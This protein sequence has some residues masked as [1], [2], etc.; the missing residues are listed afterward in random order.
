[1]VDAC[2]PKRGGN[3]RGESDWRMNWTTGIRKQEGLEKT[4]TFRSALAEITRRG[5]Q[6]DRDLPDH[7]AG[8]H[9][10][11]NSFQTIHPVLFDPVKEIRLTDQNIGDLFT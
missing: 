7:D 11:T 1:M 10:I 2:C 8:F 3:P 9:H 4:L 5:R 6:R